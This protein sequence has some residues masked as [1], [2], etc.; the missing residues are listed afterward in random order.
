MLKPFLT[1]AVLGAALAYTRRAEEAVTVATRGLREAPARRAPR[2]S[3]SLIVPTLNDAQYLELLLRSAAAQEESFLDFV[4]ADS[5]PD[6]ATAQV[7]R[8][9]GATIIKYPKGN[10]SAARNA[11]ARAAAGEVLIFADADVVLPPDFTGL[12]YDALLAGPL[13]VHPLE[14]TYDYP[15]WNLLTYW[16]RSFCRP[17]NYTTRCVGIPARLF[18]SIGGYDEA[19]NPY[20]G[21]RED[22]DLG[23]R[24]EC[25][26]GPGAVAPLDR[27][28]AISARREA[29]GG[30]G[31]SAEKFAQRPWVEVGLPVEASL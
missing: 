19:V 5:S 13:C 21:L 31:F 29:A 28:I 30:L 2:A 15:E 14:C 6:D 18:W 16:A 23:Q 8:S 12:V 1:A 3:Y 26:Y 22:L 4:V 11:G 9:H 17:Q 24:L 10:L 27:H 20:E 25:A 7:A